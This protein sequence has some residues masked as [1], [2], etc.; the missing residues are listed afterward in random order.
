M[1]RLGQCVS[2]GGEPLDQ[3]PP[4]VKSAPAEMKTREVVH[5]VI[6]EDLEE[7]ARAA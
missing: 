5:D 4:T 2:N 1:R 3:G 6:S 7:L